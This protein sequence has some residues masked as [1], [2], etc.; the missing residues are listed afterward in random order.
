LLPAWRLCG[1]PPILVAPTAVG[2]LR[3]LA[4]GGASF[5]VASQPAASERWR[6]LPPH[7]LWTN[8]HNDPA[9]TGHATCY[10][11]AVQQTAELAE[12]LAADRAAVPLAAGPALGRSLLLAA[13]LALGTVAWILWREREET[14]PLLALERFTSLSGRVSFEPHRVRV[15]LPLGPRHA[16]LFRHGLLAD[17]AGVPWLGDR[18]VEFSGG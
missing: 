10:R 8:D 6:R 16:D 15:R 5:V 12:A 17:V 3:A 11:E 9:L 18:V 4:A 1:S 14:D 2:T 7:R 13:G